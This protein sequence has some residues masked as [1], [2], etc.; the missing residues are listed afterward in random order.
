MAASFL[1]ETFV[2]GRTACKSGF[3]KDGLRFVQRAIK[4]LALHFTVG[5]EYWAM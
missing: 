4:I 5:N 1:L 2:D 3:Q